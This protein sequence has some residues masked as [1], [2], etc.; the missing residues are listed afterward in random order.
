MLIMPHNAAGMAFMEDPTKRF[1]QVVSGVEDSGDETH[2]NVA[3][4]L[5]ILKGKVLDIDV[6]RSLSENASI[7]HVDSRLVVFVYGGR[8]IWRK[9]KVLH[10]GTKVL[11]LFGCKDSC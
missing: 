3:G 11:G 6:S 2:N 8:A 7:D 10:D 9:T 1:S 4:F 5:P